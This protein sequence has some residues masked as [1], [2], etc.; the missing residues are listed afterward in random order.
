MILSLNTTTH[1]SINITPF[2]MTFG[3]R[4]PVQL[5]G[6]EESLLHPEE[7]YAK[8]IKLHL[9]DCR[10][11][12]IESQADANLASRPY[13]TNK[14]RERLFSVNELVLVK[15]SERRRAKFEQGFEG[16]FRV[17]SSDRDIY[18]LESVATGKVI[19]RH[20]SSLKP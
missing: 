10:I 3:R 4:H 7:L 12:A 18:K 15:I 16:P 5:S 11:K 1:K 19:T 9:D 2:K 20:V 14:R 6:L 13:F 17:I 8:L